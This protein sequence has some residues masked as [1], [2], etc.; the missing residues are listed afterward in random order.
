M[1]VRREQQ[2]VINITADHRRP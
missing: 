1:Y 2:V